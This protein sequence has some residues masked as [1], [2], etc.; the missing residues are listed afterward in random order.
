MKLQKTKMCLSTDPILRTVPLVDKPLL[1]DPIA[2]IMLLPI[3]SECNIFHRQYLKPIPTEYRSMFTSLFR[4]YQMFQ[5]MRSQHQ[6]RFLAS[7]LDYSG[8]RLQLV[9]EFLAFILSR[10]FGLPMSLPDNFKLLKRRTIS[11]IF[12]F[13]RSIK[14]LKTKLKT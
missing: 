14:M 1:V 12:N 9:K 13:V 6:P 5:N 2:S 3:R 7:G 4:K 11:K 10:K 8:S